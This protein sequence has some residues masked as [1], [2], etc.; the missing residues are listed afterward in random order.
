MYQ[1]FYHYAKEGLMVLKKIFV[2]FIILCVFFI[3][4]QAHGP[5][6]LD[7]AFQPVIIK[8][9][10]IQRTDHVMFILDASQSMATDRH[11]KNKLAYARSVLKRICLTMPQMQ[12]NSALRTFGHTR[13]SIEYRSEL[14]YGPSPHNKQDF[15]NTIDS[16]RFVGGM[17]ALDKALMGVMQDFK[18]ASGHISII[19]ATDGD[20]NEAKSIEAVSKLKEH[21]GLRFSLYPIMVERKHQDVMNHLVK[22]AGQG[23]VNYIDEIYSPTNMA[24]Y[25][26]KVFLSRVRH[27]DKDGDGISDDKD[28]CPDTPAGARVTINGC[29]I[30][31]N[32]KFASNSWELKEDMMPY[33]NEVVAILKNNP[34]LWME[35]QG[36][37]D[38]TGPADHNYTLSRNRAMAVMTYLISKGVSADRLTSTGYGETKPI[39]TNDTEE[40]KALN[41]RV[42][43]SPI[44]R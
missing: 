28:I 36:H 27:Q 17:S 10:F 31:G 25:V 26:N 44:K 42:E 4:C 16:I 21:F 18:D 32:I 6:S 41:R 15:N 9:P 34:N 1:Q 29:W 39:S 19:I 2:F 13:R 11:G 23:F 5:K 8:G 7:E 38:S 35:V 12:I 33:L 20:V 30:L 22:A 3:G 24:T 14:V 40:G 37:T 43:L